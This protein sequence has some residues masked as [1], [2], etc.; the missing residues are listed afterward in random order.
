MK[1]HTYG[2]K[3]PEKGDRGGTFCPAISANM[4][5]IDGH[6]HDGV[7]SP[8]V[9]TKN[10]ERVTLTASQAEWTLDES[11]GEYKQTMTLPAGNDF[12]QVLLV[13]RITSGDEAGHIVHPT[14]KKITSSTF[15]IYCS[16]NTIDME[17][18]IV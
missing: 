1:T 9:S 18:N 4:E 8:L 13:I 3:Q 2:L 16:D 7:T 10:L 15:D 5:Q 14:V 12:D 17:I 6:I 11:M